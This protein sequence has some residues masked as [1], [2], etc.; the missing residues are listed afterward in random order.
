M[1]AVFN[2]WLGTEP[3]CTKER[4]YL[5]SLVAALGAVKQQLHAYEVLA[6]NISHIKPPV[7]EQ[8][9]ESI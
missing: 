5:Y 7:E 4:E 2:Q 3:H 8:P 1:F 9:N 6:K